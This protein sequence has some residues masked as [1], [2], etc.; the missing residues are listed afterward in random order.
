MTAYI[1]RHHGFHVKLIGAGTL[2]GLAHLFFYGEEPGWTLGGFAL[3]WSVILT[4]TR[5]DVRASRAARVALAMATLFGVM[6]VDDPGPL[7]SLLFLVAIGS[8]TL[9]PLRRF[10]DA[11]RWAA[12]LFAHGVLGIVAPLRDARRLARAEGRRDHRRIVKVAAVL[13]LPM[14]GSA[15]FL[16]L[17]AQANPVIANAFAAIRFPDL[18]TL[19]LRLIFSGCFLILVWSSLRPR[20]TL[21]Q[22][23]VLQWD[24]AAMPHLAHGTLILSLAAFNLIFAIQNA[25]DIAFLWSGAPLPEGV[26]LADYAHQGAYPLIVTALLAGGFVLLAARPDGA[27]RESRTL[28]RLILLWVAQNVLLV[29]SSILRTL[30][31]IAA[32]SLT[33]W[34]IAALAWM[35]LVAV[36]LILIGWRMLSGY[37]AR[38]LVNAN[39]LAAGVVL[40]AGC[41]SD[42]GGIAAQ[43]NVAHARSVADLDLCYLEYLGPSALLPLIALERRAAGPVLRQRTANLIG[44]T[45]SETAR[46]Q[47]DWHSWTWR[48]ARR[49]SAAH[50]LVGKRPAP[51]VLTVCGEPLK[52]EAAETPLTKAARS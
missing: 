14:I 39:A 12:R 20:R 45:M 50:A 24:A 33:G 30:D 48:D 41:A 4:L 31:Y 52:T 5:V 15:V 36:G 21:R 38:W 35:A 10:D 28:R 11:I 34:R 37:S 32:Y 27:A 25:L 8:A 46:R 2:I 16:T 29:A 3:A 1:S 13:V 18:S 23:G 40:T 42:P 49:L 44:L 26:T 6:L 47:A 22:T 9:L 51:H 7:K 17:F 43:W 19:L